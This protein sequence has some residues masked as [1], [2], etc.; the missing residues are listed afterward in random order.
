MADNDLIATINLIWST[1][2][3]GNMKCPKKYVKEE[4]IMWWNMHFF[5]KCPKIEDV[6][7]RFFFCFQNQMGKMGHF[8]KKTSVEKWGI[9]KKMHM[10]SHDKFLFHILFG[11]FHAT[12]CIPWISVPH[13]SGAKYTF[14]KSFTDTTDLK[15]LN[16]TRN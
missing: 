7:F 11:A 12:P 2:G 14:I 4:F 13:Q 3:R 9:S 6:H 5:S 1:G 15:A 10:P 16:E 8:K